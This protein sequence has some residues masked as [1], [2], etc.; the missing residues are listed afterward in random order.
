MYSDLKYPTLPSQPHCFIV[1][2]V[3][4]PLILILL[5]LVSMLESRQ[6]FVAHLIP[7]LH[8]DFASTARVFKVTQYPQIHIYIRPMISYL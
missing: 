4:I 6:F 5:A 1:L 7:F 8:N 3:Y 2:Q